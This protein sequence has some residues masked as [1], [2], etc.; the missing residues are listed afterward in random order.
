MPKVVIVH[1]DLGVGGAERLI[2]DAGLAL[3]D[4][5]H[6]V[7][8]YTGH[9]D[10]HRCFQETADGTLEVIALGSWIPRSIFNRFHA[11]LA[12][13][14]IMLIAI[15]LVIFS[16]H[17][18][19]L[20]DQVPTCIPIFK[21][22]D[23]R[24]KSRI[25]Y[26]C[27]FPDQLL[28]DRE[29]LA[30]RIYRSLIDWLE[31][32][33]TGMADIVLVNSNFTRSV[34][35]RT[36]E[37]LSKRELTVLYPC[38]NVQKLVSKRIEPTTYSELVERCRNLASNHYVFLS[39]NRFERKKN[40]ALAIEALYE[41]RKE[42]DENESSNEK[43][44]EAHLIVA[45]GYDER[46][47][48]CVSYYKHLEDLVRDLKLEAHVTFLQSPDDREKVSLLSC[49]DAVIYTPENEHFGIVPLEAMAFSRPVI[50]CASGGPLETVEDNTTGF[51]CHSDKISFASAMFRMITKPEKAKLMGKNGL[52]RVKK[53]Y[54]YEVFR[55]SL[56]RICFP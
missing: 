27:H 37:T 11:L 42:L 10:K 49:C 44:Y 23:Y 45:G 31:E 13:L 56:N 47:L 52:E 28:T 17:D 51:L 2:I 46:I 26:Y 40:L 5:G 24:N 39:L 21:W 48:D 55:E 36:F 33:T 30:K 35:R 20:C 34:V 43:T 19:V 25:I 32:R 53:L 54:S 50:A 12:Y 9:H 22:F 16:T 18:L 3:Q 15:Y 38:V 6:Q 4:K 7:K 14:K 1:P 29:T 41:L 8:F